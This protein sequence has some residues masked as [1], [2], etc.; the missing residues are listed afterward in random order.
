MVGMCWRSNVFRNEAASADANGYAILLLR[1][2]LHKCQDGSLGVS[3]N[4]QTSSTECQKNTRVAL[5]LKPTSQ[6]HAAQGK[7]S[8]PTNDRDDGSAAIWNRV[9]DS[10][11]AGQ[12]FP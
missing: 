3:I 6:P 11:T 4:E 2:L 5:V 12:G 9:C 10:C 1:A 8:S 7:G